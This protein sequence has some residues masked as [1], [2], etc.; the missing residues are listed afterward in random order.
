MPMRVKVRK[1][2]RA[3]QIS[4]KIWNRDTFITRDK[5]DTGEAKIGIGKYTLFYDEEV[6]EVQKNTVAKFTERVMD[7]KKI[8][9]R[10]VV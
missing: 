8:S 4:Q 5:I 10:S 2:R 1:N 3:R 6:Q 7:L 9:K